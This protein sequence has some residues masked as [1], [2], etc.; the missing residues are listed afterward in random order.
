MF[1]TRALTVLVAL[2]IFAGALFFLPQPAWALVLLPV[3]GIAGWEWG[4]LAGYAGTA[5]NVYSAVL[6][7]SAA[8]VWWLL[9][10]LSVALWALSGL[11]WITLVPFWLRTHWKP[12]GGA[13][14]ALAGWIALVP[15]WLALVDLQPRPWVLLLVM[16]IVWIADTAAYLA[17]RQWGRRKLA[18]RISPGKSW[19]GVGGAVAALALYFV[20]LWFVFPGGERVLPAMAGLLLFVAVLTLGIEGDLFESLLKRQAG[21]K[22]SGNLLPGHGG[23][24]DRIDALTSTMPVAA[25]ALHVLG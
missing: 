10:T 22:D 21:M 14:H 17:G 1:A 3:L 12:T 13:V 19:E 4:R 2:P 5:R 18:P 15:M 23:V 6:V 11:F 24:L 25:L 8:V 16:S 9:P 7:L 20:L